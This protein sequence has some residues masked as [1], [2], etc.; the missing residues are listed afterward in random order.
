MYLRALQLGHATGTRFYLAATLG[1]DGRV[2]E[3][4]AEY[5]EAIRLQPDSV[6]A[7]SSLGVLLCEV[8]HD[9]TAAAEAFRQAIQLDPE[10]GPAHYNLANALQAEGQ[11]DEAIAEYREAIRLDPGD[12]RCAQT[13]ASRWFRERNSTARSPN[14]ARR[15][16]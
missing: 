14:T 9:A 10:N 11:A 13:W 5:R 2:D 7:W 6:H 12:A 4:I 15:S 3:A 8:K 16:A 1:R